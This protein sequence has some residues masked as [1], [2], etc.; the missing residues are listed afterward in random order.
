MLIIKKKYLV[1]SLNEIRRMNNCENVS[2]CSIVFK[3][4]IIKL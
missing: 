2:Y 4:E 1:E 3:I